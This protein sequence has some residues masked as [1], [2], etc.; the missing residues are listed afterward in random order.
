MQLDGLLAE[1][2]EMRAF[3]E[4]LKQE[5]RHLMTG[6]SGSVRTLLLADLK[7]E[8]G[9]PVVV[10]CDDLFHAQSL[11]DDLMN[12]VSEDDVDL[13]PAEEMLVAEAAVSSPEFRAQRVRAL[14][15]LADG[16][17]GVVV[18]SVSGLR[19]RLCPV[20]FWRK[21]SLRFR[22]GD[23]KDIEEMREKLVSMGYESVRMVERPGDFSVRGSIVDVYA[24]NLDNPVRIDFFDTEI[25]SL[26]FFD[27]ADQRS[28]EKV[29][30]V[31]ILPATDFIASGGMLE[32]GAE[33][34]QENVRDYVKDLADEEDRKLLAD[35]LKA[36]TDDW[37]KG[38]LAPEHIVFSREIYGRGGVS[39]LDY[40]EDDG[41]VVFDDYSRLR[42]KASDLEKDDAQWIT[43]KIEEHRIY[44]MERV[45]F[46]LPELERR[47]GHVKVFMA[48]LQKGMG[49]M[50]LASVNDVRARSVQQFFGQLPLLKVEAQRYQKTGETV[51]VLVSDSERIAKV[52][53]MFDDIGINAIVTKDG[54]IQEG[55]FQIVKGSLQN[56]FELPLSRT[57]VLTENELFERARKRQPKHQTMSNTERLKSY[58]DLEPGDYVVHVNHGIGRYMGMETL[59]VSGRHQDYMT[60]MYR[61]DAKLFIPVSQLDRIQK[62]VSSEGREPK[63]NRL[64]NG[65]WEKTKKR[66]ASRLE[67]IADE[68]VE[69]Y[70]KRESEKGY[71]FPKDDSL[72][73]E[74]EDAFPYTETPDQLRS[75]KEIKLDMEKPK[76]MDRLLIGDVG[77]G[78]TEVALRAA[79]KAAENGKQVAFIAPT[80]LLVQQHYDTIVSRF[81]GFPVEIGILSRFSTPKQVKETLAKLKNGEID[82]IVGTHRLLSKDVRF[83]D[84]GLL[85]IDEEQRFGVRHKERL[86]ELKTSVDVLTL[87]ATP[88]PRTLNMS[89]LGVRDL[90]VIETAPLNRYPVQT[91]V[92]EQNY[93]VVQTGIRREMARGG[94]VFYLHNRV[95]DIETVV[96]TLNSLVPEA[97]IGYAHGQMTETQMEGVLSDFIAGE[98]DVLVTTTIIETG[99]DIPNVNTLFVEDADHMGLAQLYQLRGRVGRSNRVAYAYFMYQP[100]KVMTEAGEKRLEAIKDFTELG[101]GFKIAMRDLSIRGAGN[102]LGKQQHGFIESV[103]YDLYT[104]MLSEAVAR[105]RGVRPEPKT[106]CEIGLSVE[107]YIPSDYIEDSR[108]KIEIYK[109]IHQLHGC[110]EYEEIQKDLTDRFGEYPDECANL[111]EVGLLKFYADHAMVERITQ[112]DRK[113]EILLSPEATERLGLKELMAGLAECS[114]KMTFGEDHR[115]TLVTLLKGDETG[116]AELL[117]MLQQIM[118]SFAASLHNLS[119]KQEKG[120]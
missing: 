28:L 22:T 24:L 49:R 67:D 33:I 72:Q 65:E 29:D 4:S 30:D 118:R 58:T 35:N 97:R 98:Y 103:G 12:V 66:V 94:Q 93:D 107:A 106:D 90:S 115:K 59:E 7:N 80:T 40:L 63:V 64:G 48:L 56:G 43:E 78:K 83:A 27:T 25:D 50:R 120:A 10:V 96:D 101:S 21:S 2:D 37:R 51:V 5:G 16:S 57:V 117:Y 6:V 84:L 1:T 100:D 102:M 104:K 8:T 60:I 70:S 44:P 61:D 91:Y 88:I 14:Q 112:Y 95:H 110:D 81:A 79:F 85:I 52:S 53:Q 13:F 75:A 46:E 99:V 89:M 54:A 20:D 69:L 82:I 34:L 39:L 11:A 76:P 62:Y 32:K 31:E 114:L 45:G 73:Q 116:D 41:L 23:E 108:Q 109:R 71:A 42:E 17:A 9:H 18:T 92:M 47:D 15:R 36:V 74:F 119:E 77:Y 55:V 113:I 3:H 105:K 111:L 38:V 87:T 26:R 19:R 68:L 86:K